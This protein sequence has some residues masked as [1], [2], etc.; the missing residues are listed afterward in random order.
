MN[1]LIFFIIFIV[2]FVIRMPISFGMIA[3]SSAYMV[4]TPGL[5]ATL[6]LVPMQLLS[7]L[8]KN[9][10]IIAIPLFVFMAHIMNSGKVTQM[11][12]EFA[13][14]I[15]GKKKGGLAHVNI[16]ASLVFSGMTGSAAADASGLGVM[17]IKAMREAGYSDGFSCAVTAAS[18][19]MGPV[20][21]PSLPMI[22][23]SMLSGASIGAL[24]MGGMI[25]GVLM[26]IMLMIYISFIARRRNYP[27]DRSYLLREAIVITLKATP[28]L[29]SVV[30][31]LGG[32]YSGVVTA[33]EAGALASLYALVISIFVYRAIGLKDLWNCIKETLKTCGSV[34][35]IIAAS[36]A[37]AYIIAKEGI[38]ELF[39]SI[40]L[41]FTANKYVL[42]L[43]VNILFLVLGMFVDTSTIMVIFIPIVLPLAQML[44]ID[45]VHFGVI[46]VLNIMIGLS[47]PP[48]GLLLFITS[49]ISGTPLSEVMK[50]IIPM[51]FVMI[52]ELFLVTYIPALALFIPN[53][54][55]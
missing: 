13:N 41:N 49:N 25:P 46:I 27:T 23:Y 45:L 19:T 20:F 32:I 36:Y 4:L 28:A 29:F 6:R 51:V 37:F 47:T 39:A 53:T 50:E 40:M 14:V 55:G 35:I 17:E 43:M 26:A 3:A 52:L 54:F 7:N 12:F 2:G 31:L 38:P 48:F 9:F 24:F 18:A 33:T 44:N 8:E 34:A 16:F 22:L 42:L 30:I 5:Q 10:S 11:I 15:V 21:P 1:L